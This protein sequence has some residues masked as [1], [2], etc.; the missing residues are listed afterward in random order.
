[1][2]YLNKDDFEEK[3]IRKKK[4]KENE[5]IRRKVKLWVIFNF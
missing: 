3:E 1:M 5:K 2:L 4:K